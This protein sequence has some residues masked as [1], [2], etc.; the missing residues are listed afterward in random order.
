MYSFCMA[1][2]YLLHNCKISASGGPTDKSK[3]FFEFEIVKFMFFYKFSST[4]I[5][6]SNYSEKILIK[7]HVKNEDQFYAVWFEGV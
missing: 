7:R 2:K 6:F 3:L 4:D 1:A 5:I